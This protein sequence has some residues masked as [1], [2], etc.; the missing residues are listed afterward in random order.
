VLRQ[1]KVSP[2]ALR[3]ALAE[4]RRQEYACLPGHVHEDALGIAVPVRDGRAAVIAALAAI[5]PVGT[6]RQAV[7]GMLATAARGI[8]RALANPAR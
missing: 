4:V 5:V 1:P 8:T 7:T 6:P 3:G 2:A